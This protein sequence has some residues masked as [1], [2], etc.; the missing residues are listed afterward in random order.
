MGKTRTEN[1]KTQRIWL[2][3]FQVGYARLRLEGRSVADLKGHQTRIAQYKA[4][5]TRLEKK[6]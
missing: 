3:L 1:L 6:E 2:E 5:I 4:T